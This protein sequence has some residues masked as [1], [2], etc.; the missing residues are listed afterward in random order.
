MGSTPQKLTPVDR[1]IFQ[2]VSNLIFTGTKILISFLNKKLCRSIVHLKPI[3]Y[4]ISFPLFLMDKI[5]ISG[6]FR[7]VNVVIYTG[8]KVHIFWSLIISMGMK[9]QLCDL[10]QASSNFFTKCAGVFSAVLSLLHN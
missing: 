3:V 2:I 10:P 6:F 8:C 5:G 9:Y 1:N 7:T 4:C